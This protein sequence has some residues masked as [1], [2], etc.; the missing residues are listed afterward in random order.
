ML[1]A[2]GAVRTVAGTRAFGESGDGGP[3]V[4]ATLLRPFGLALDRAG[5]LYIGGYASYRVRK[6]TPG[7]IIFTFAGNG[8]FGFSGDGGPATSAQLSVWGLAV[9]DD[10]G[11]LYIADGISRI[12]KVTQDGIIT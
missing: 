3:A 4:A 9:D 8:Q 2:S 10:A 7:G 6:V 5:N 1:T 11:N 12:R